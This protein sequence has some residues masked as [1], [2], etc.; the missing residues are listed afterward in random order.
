MIIPEGAGPFPLVAV[1]HG[2]SGMGPGC[3][4]TLNHVYIDYLAL[5]LVASGYAVVA[6]DYQNLGVAEG[7]HPYAVGRAAA[8]NTLDAI[9]AAQRLNQDALGGT[10]F[11]DELFIMGHS[12]GGH[13]ALFAHQFF[14]TSGITGFRLLGDIPF[15]PAFGIPYGAGAN[16]ANGAQASNAV[17]VFTVMMLLGHGAYFGIPVT[18]WLTTDAAT[19][20]PEFAQTQC[21]SDFAS[22]VTSNWR[23]HAALF[24]PEFRAAA[25][26]C[27]FDGNPCPGFS[28]W[29]ED[30]YASTPGYF[31]SDVPVLM[32]LGGRDVEVGALSVACIQ[33][34]LR[35]N[36]TPV[37]TC[38]YSSADHITVTINGMADVLG[39]MQ[40]RRDGQDPDVCPAT[41]T[42]T[43][44]G[45]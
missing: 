2:T 20:L 34:A 41:L 14:S 26:T 45:F 5:P 33:A 19:R 40:G 4:A 21:Y 7:T 29:A 28:P 8:D 37:R 13:A 9:R 22:S 27:A 24:T 17:T 6:T 12:Q 30:V 43:C 11:T 10:L 38:F 15:A 39:W 44:P 3:G 25:G 18:D 31:T 32:L 1:D 36:N 23:T 35:R 42:T 16:I